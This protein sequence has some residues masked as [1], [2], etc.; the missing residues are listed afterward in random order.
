MAVISFAFNVSFHRINAPSFFSLQI[1]F[2]DVELFTIYLNVSLTL[3]VC[4]CVYYT[5]AVIL[6][7]F[8]NV[9]FAVRLIKYLVGRY[10]QCANV[11]TIY[12]N[13]CMTA[14]ILNTHADTQIYIMI[15][16]LWYIQIHIIILKYKTLNCFKLDFVCWARMSVREREHANIF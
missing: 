5:C 2:D 10:L 3:C 1:K 6:F 9:S 15:Y 13:T 8:F 11:P 7:I 16:G 4:V 14:Y 12:T